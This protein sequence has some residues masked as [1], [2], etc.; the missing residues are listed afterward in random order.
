MP[1]WETMEL[2][3]F[4]EYPRWW[5]EQQHPNTTG[6]GFPPVVVQP[7]YG[8]GRG[9]GRLPFRS[10]KAAPSGFGS[11]A[12]LDRPVQSTWIST[13]QPSRTPSTVD[14]Y[15][16]ASHLE[17]QIESLQVRH[18]DFDHANH[19]RLQPS[20][21]TEVSDESSARET[22]TPAKVQTSQVIA[23][24]GV[25]SPVQIMRRPISQ[26]PSLTPSPPKLQEK[27]EAKMETEPQ[28]VVA[29]GPRPLDYGIP[30]LPEPHVPRRFEAPDAHLKVSSAPA[31]VQKPANQLFRF[32]PKIIQRG[33]T[34]EQSQF[35]THRGGK[36][37]HVNDR[38]YNNSW[39]GNGHGKSGDSGYATEPEDRKGGDAKSQSDLM[40]MR[41]N[42]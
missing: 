20:R 30:Q 10:I 15:D 17:S 37:K 9:R 22:A 31:D 1:D 3:G 28:P 16:A 5:R 19:S 12:P 21:I 27:T 32:Q 41:S 13:P 7:S 40:D 8:F 18:E 25:R 2:L 26:Y 29:T 24:L 39:R 38:V 23:K 35:T 33:S 4:R 34:F 14:F 42:V 36:V 6:L 11:G